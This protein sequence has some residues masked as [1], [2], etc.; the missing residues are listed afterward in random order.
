ME[1]TASASLIQYKPGLYSSLIENRSNVEL[2]MARLFNERIMKDR[3][4]GTKPVEKFDIARAG[5]LG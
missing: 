1:P 3:N 5:I 4:A 2:F